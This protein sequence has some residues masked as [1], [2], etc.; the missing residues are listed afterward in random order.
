MRFF[1]KNCWVF[2]RMNLIRLL[3]IRKIGRAMLRGLGTKVNNITP[4]ELR[5]SN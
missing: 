5:V 1:L 4:F 3:L 2:S